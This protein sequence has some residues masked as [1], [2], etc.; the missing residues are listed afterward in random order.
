MRKSKSKSKGVIAPVIKQPVIQ[1]P[2]FTSKDEK[3]LMFD[4][5][6][7]IFLAIIGVLLL[8]FFIYLLVVLNICGN[9]ITAYNK[10]INSAVCNSTDV[11]NAINSLKD[12][13]GYFLFDGI[14]SPL[15]DRAINEINNKCPGYAPTMGV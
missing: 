7:V 15:V 11:I 12:C 5:A 4:R 13:K 9:A 8:S 3:I 1:Q 14:I 2:T 6:M 10:V